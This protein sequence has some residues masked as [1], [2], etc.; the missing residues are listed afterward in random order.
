MKLFNVELS[1]NSGDFDAET[2]KKLNYFSKKSLRPKLIG[3]IEK[4]HLHLRLM[5]EYKKSK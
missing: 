3:F 2:F 1:R 5:D 4:H